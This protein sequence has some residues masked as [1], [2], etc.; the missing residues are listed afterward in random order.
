MRKGETTEKTESRVAESKA[1]LLFKSRVSIAL[2]GTVAES[3]IL[4]QESRPELVERGC[5]WSKL[6]GKKKGVAA[7]RRGKRAT[8]A[9][10]AAGRDQF[11]F[12][13]LL[14]SRP[15]QNSSVVDPLVTAKDETNA[16]Y[17]EGWQKH[18]DSG[19]SGTRQR[20][21]CCDE[22]HRTKGGDEIGQS[23]LTRDG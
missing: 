15:Q 13:G 4:P 18:A 6:D 20:R 19:R 12:P 14:Y 5:G 21:A 16:R 17:V 22:L 8:C 9:I 23:R 2:V 10:L 1:I 7:T 11:L 3:I